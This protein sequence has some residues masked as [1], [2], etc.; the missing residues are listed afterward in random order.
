MKKSQDAKA[1]LSGVNKFFRLHDYSEDVKEKIDTFSLK[2]KVCILWEYLKNVKGIREE[3]LTWSEFGRIFRNKYI[4]E[5][6]YENRE[7]EY[8]ELKMGSMTDE[9]YANIFLEL[10]KDVPY[11]EEGKSKIQGFMSGLLVGFKEKI[12]FDEPRSLE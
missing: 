5:R 4:S 8:Y 9:E 2:G 11:L 3:E 6:Y 7:K 1:W 12:E 10:L